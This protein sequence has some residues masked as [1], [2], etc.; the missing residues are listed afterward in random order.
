MH[1]CVICSY[2]AEQLLTLSEAELF[3]SFKPSVQEL[4]DTTGP[5]YWDAVKSAKLTVADAVACTGP[6]IMAMKRTE[7]A[8]QINI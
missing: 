2:Q 6:F 4:L 8:A 5:I 3:F 1:G 7:C